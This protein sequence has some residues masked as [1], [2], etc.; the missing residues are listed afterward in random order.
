MPRQDGEGFA[1]NLR[2]RL[3]RELPQFQCGTTARP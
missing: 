2:K 1:T 3:T